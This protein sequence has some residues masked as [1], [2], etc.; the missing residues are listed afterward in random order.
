[1]KTPAFVALLALFLLVAV[2]VRAEE[3]V[4]HVAV[5]GTAITRVQP[6]LLRWRL[7]VARRGAD[8][9]PL[10]EAHARDVAAVLA[11]L[12]GQG[13]AEREIQTARMQFSEH[14]EYRSKSRVMEGYDASTSITFSVAELGKYQALWQGLARLEGV[15]VDGV[16]WDSSRRIELQNSS[17]IDALLAAKAKAEAMAGALEVKLAEPIVIEELPTFGDDR[18]RGLRGNTANMVSYQ[19]GGDEGDDAVA[20]G[21]IEIRTRVQVRFRISPR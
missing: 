4:P 5:F 13:I 18:F 1:M 7:T 16:A 20:P 8:V 14:Y 9:A 19:P 12:G 17:R 6:D 2:P 15:S 11:F 10:A 3:S 21:E